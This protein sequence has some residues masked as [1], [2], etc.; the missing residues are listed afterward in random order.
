MLLLMPRF[1][2]LDIEVRSLYK[3]ITSKYDFLKKK[4]RNC[5]T[6]DKKLSLLYLIR[7][8]QAYKTLI[9]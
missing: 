3:K 5:V 9:N 8:H 7:H 2:R 6:T 4:S 1:F